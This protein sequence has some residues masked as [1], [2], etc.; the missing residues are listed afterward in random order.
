MLSEVL[1][2]A[3]E[4]RM[5]AVKSAPINRVSCMLVKSFGV[6]SVLLVVRGMCMS[7]VK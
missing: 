2:T 7:K 4:A 5:E 1:T 6:G 3:G